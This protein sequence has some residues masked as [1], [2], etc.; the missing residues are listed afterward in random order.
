M[1]LRGTAQAIRPVE[2]GVEP[3]RRV[4]S[5]DLRRQHV[6]ELVVE[7]L[8]VRGGVE[9]TVAL[10]P[11]T[12]GAGQPVEHLPGILLAPRDR[13]AVAIERW[14]AVGADLRHAGLSEVRLGE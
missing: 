11:V 3:L 2:P 1:A 9:V 13:P 7:R 14:V 5:P 8:R 12:P 6:A 4:G 10:A